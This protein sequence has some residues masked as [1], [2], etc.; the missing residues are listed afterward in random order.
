MM[1]APQSFA[2]G[3]ELPHSH[4]HGW[5]RLSDQPVPGED[6]FTNRVKIFVTSVRK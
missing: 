5:Q 4:E 6:P 1:G 2:D 3:V